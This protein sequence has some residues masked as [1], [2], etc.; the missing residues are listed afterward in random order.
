M[1]PGRT[2]SGR[3]CRALQ[4]ETISY[5]SQIRREGSEGFWWNVIQYVRTSVTENT[6]TNL[7]YLFLG[8]VPPELCGYK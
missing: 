1:I 3:P 7:M 6:R 8:F 5:S 4:H 2:Y